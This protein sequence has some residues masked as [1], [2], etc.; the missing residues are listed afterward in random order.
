MAP[1][2][3]TAF[4]RLLPPLWRRHEP[5]RMRIHK[6]DGVPQAIIEEEPE[7]SLPVVE[8]PSTEAALAEIEALKARPFDLSQDVFVARLFRIDERRTLFFFMHHHTIWDGW[9]FDLFLKDLIA[10]YEGGG[11]GQAPLPSG[12]FDYAARHRQQ[13]EDGY[14]SDGL[15]AVVKK[16]QPLPPVPEL[17]VDR[18]RPRLF[19]HRGDWHAFPI[20]REALNAIRSLAKDNR[21][22]PF[23]VMLSIFRAFLWRVTGTEDIVIGAPVQARETADTEP[24]IGC[25]V[26]T[27]FLR[28]QVHAQETLSDLI[29]RERSVVIDAFAHQDVPV[30]L[31]VERTVSTR[32]PSRTPLSQVMLSHQQVSGRP[33]QLGDVRLEQLHVNPGATP[34]DLML[35]IMEDEDKARGVFH[36]STGLFS[37]AQIEA[38]SD[39]FEVFYRAALDAPGAE[40]ATLPLMRAETIMRVTESARGPDV[41]LGGL[42]HVAHRVRLHAAEMSDRVALI[43]GDEEITYAALD[44]QASSIAAGLRAMGVRKGD[45]VGL[46]LH[47]T[48]SVVAAI[49]GVWR[50]GAAYVPLDPTYPASRLRYMIEDSGMAVILGDEHECLEGLSVARQSLDVVCQVAPRPDEDILPSPTDRAYVIYTSGSTGKPKGVENRHGPLTNFLHAMADAPGMAADD[51]LLAVTTLAFDISILELFLPLMVGAKTVI[52]TRDETGDGFMLMDLIEAHAI[53][54]MQGT[55]ATWRLLLEG[56]WEGRPGLKA[57]CG[58]EGLPQALARELLERVGSLWNMYGPTETTV[59][60]AVKRIT[61]PAG[62]TIGGPIANTS[63]YVLDERGE[64]CPPGGDG[65]LWIGGAGVATG[66]WGKEALTAERFCPDPFV[67]GGILYRTGDIARRRPDGEYVVFGRRDHQVKLRGFRIE[68]PEIEAALM[69]HAAVSHAVCALKQDAAGDP[70]LVAY[71][72]YQ[73]NQTATGSELRR[74]VRSSLP[75][76]MVPQLFVSLTQLPLT[77]NGKINRNALPEPAELQPRARKVIAPRNSVETALAAIWSDILS[78]EPVSVTDNFFEL[79]GQ[80]LQA[81][82]MVARLRAREGYRISPRAVIF[83]TLEQLAAGATPAPEDN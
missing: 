70:A 37:S 50:A 65:E 19:D 35:A 74:A 20:N 61:D 57:L 31:V 51:T 27:I 22:T 39:A 54:V 13:T 75:P 73:P 16:L 9:S 38:L 36:Y 72:Q 83:E 6:A 11:A 80:S 62:I 76:Y 18:P 8:M 23:I 2:M 78:V 67:P 77:E 71:I 66:Y 17:P 5:M 49:L 10:F 48:P 25:F 47:R 58:G 12:Y 14:F 28:E 29:D 4:N 7:I 21:A 59:W 79:G 69:Q 64:L 32:D 24:L 30:E 46:L 81:A 44:Q 68:L 15:E 34:T 26:N 82:Q 33:D 63:L 3:A 1:S 41:P 43:G 55:P 45:L 52:A 42:D 53:S 56:G 40:L 60:S